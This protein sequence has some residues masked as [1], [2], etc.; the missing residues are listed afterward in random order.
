MGKNMVGQNDMGAYCH[1]IKTISNEN[2]LSLEF[3]IVIPLSFQQQ[4]N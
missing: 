3:I 1:P 4:T 2:S